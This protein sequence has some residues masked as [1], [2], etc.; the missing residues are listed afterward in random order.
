[1]YTHL[2]MHIQYLHTFVFRLAGGQETLFFEMAECSDGDQ[3]EDQ[4]CSPGH[5]RERGDQTAAHGLMSVP[6][7][8]NLLKSDSHMQLFLISCMCDQL[9]NWQGWYVKEKE[10]LNQIITC[11]MHWVC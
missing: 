7:R 9:H 3:G 8:L 10:T 1:M 11:G 4:C 5:A 2:Y 6:F